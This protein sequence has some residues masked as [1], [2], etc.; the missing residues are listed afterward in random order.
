M[1]SE[2]VFAALSSVLLGA[3]KLDTRT[4]IGGALI[5]A[6]AIWAAWAEQGETP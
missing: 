5:L 2:I 1:L 3:A 6:A 4:L